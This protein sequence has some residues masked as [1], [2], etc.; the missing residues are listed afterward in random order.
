MVPRRQK[1]TSAAP[2]RGAHLPVFRWLSRQNPAC[3]I[4]A[5]VLLIIGLCHIS[6]SPHVISRRATIHSLV[7]QGTFVI[8]ASNPT[9]DK[10]LI[11]G[12]F[13][14]HQPPLH[15]VLGAMAYAP[16]YAAGM[17]VDSSPQTRRWLVET[18]L[19][20]AVNGVIW[21]IALLA[22]HR[23]LNR[24]AIDDAAR[25]AMTVSLAVATTVFSYLTTY[26]AHS[27]TAA[28]LLLGFTSLWSAQ[29]EARLF[30]P[31]QRLSIPPLFS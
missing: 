11:D 3:L 6:G 14:S 18:F 17:R 21:I 30:P 22:F 15:A 24:T 29:R 20:V 4:S 28:L 5:Y 19:I 8:P 2:E 27:I 7:S 12:Q 16:L 31:R 13:Y 26:N 9:I 1:L 23:A 10:V 25:M